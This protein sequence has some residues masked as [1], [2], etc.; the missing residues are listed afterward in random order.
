MISLKK[1]KSFVAS[2]NLQ[3]MFLLSFVLWVYSFRGF[4]TKKLALM[5]D[6]I[7]YYGH[8]QYYLDNISM[9]VY[10]MWDPVRNFGVP[11]EFFL[12]RI[13]PYNP[14]CYLILVL[15]K[16]GFGFDSAYLIWITLYYFLGMIGFYLIAKHLFRNKTAAFL[17]F[18]I[19]MFSSLGTRLFDSYI[20]L[21]IVPMIW[22]FSFLSRFRF[23]F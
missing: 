22:F 8:F 4:I 19:L 11:I 10:P 16:I 7:A 1:I 2:K 17:A 3:L 5:Y 14:L 18:L 13:C 23:Y 20:N 21:V 9:G 6:A 15:D 12:R